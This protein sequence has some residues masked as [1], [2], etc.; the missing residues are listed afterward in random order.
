MHLEDLHILVLGAIDHDQVKAVLWDPMPGGSGLIDQILANFGIIVSIA[1]ELISG[2]P[3]D[4]TSSCNDCLQ[5]FRN[6]FYHKYLDRH[7]ALTFLSVHGAQLTTSHPIPPSQGIETAN[8][9]IGIPV[10]DAESKL[11]HLLEA[12]GFTGGQFQQHIRFRHK[13]DLGHQ[14]GSTTPDVFFVGD[15]DD[16]E[17]LGVCIYLDGLSSHIHGNSAT[18]EIDNE[19]RSWLKN[20]GYQVIAISYV[21]LSDKNAMKAAFRRLAKYLSGKVLADRISNDTS[22]YS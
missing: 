22:W 8:P 15:E 6:G 11:K 12:A 14:I 10:N 19:I 3:S 21:D 17:D 18:A 13:I 5:T 7:A 2:C 4:C 20:N 1:T 9:N 16:P